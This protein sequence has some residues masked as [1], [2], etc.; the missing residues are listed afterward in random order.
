[1]K[2]PNPTFINV[3]WNQHRVGRLAMNAKYQ[4]IFEYDATWVAQAQ[5]I[6][7]FDL[8]LKT[9][10]FTAKIDPFDGLFGVFSDSLPDGWGTLLLDRWLAQQGIRVASLN[11]L[12]RL[13]LIGESGMGALSYQPAV[14]RAEL[15]SQ[16]SISYYANQVEQILQ[17]QPV[18]NLAE[19]VAKA[20]SPGGARPKV[21]MQIDQQPWLI[22][23]NAPNDPADMGRLEYSYAQAARAAG[24]EI[25][26]VRLFEGNYFGVKRFDRIAGKRRHM[27][28]AAGLLG[29]SHRYPSLDY[30]DLI[31]A[32]WYLTRSGKE[33]EKVYR[34]MIFNVLCLNRDDHSKNF[35]FL[36]DLERWT[37]APSYDLVYSHGFQM[38][39]STTINGQG[40]PTKKDVLEV[41]QKTDIPAKKAN[42][43]L[44][45]LIY[46]TTELR[47]MIKDR[48]KE[49]SPI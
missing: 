47:L 29:A 38:Q 44:D 1:M 15:D 28:T 17:E 26:E 18:E 40:I 11:S 9:G 13:L 6:S 19:W 3:M 34:Q 49:T 42:Q 48:F 2:L 12:Q 33:A 8:P 14:H 37:Y 5:S 16:K 32:T 25:P 24:L 23:F 27:L 20:G 30:V 7:P 4:A 10:L 39:H 35:S 22:K 21:L 43:I 36:F 46:S 45:E 31:R 41:A